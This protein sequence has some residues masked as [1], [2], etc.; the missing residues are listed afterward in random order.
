MDGGFDF[1]GED[2]AV[3]VLIDE[4]DFGLIFVCPII[5][6]DAIRDE[7][8]HDVVLGQRA[9]EGVEAVRRVEEDVRGDAVASAEQSGVSDVDFECVL[10]GVG[11]ERQAALGDAVTDLDEAGGAE[12]CECRGIL[13]GASAGLDGFVLEFS[14]FLRELRGEALPDV[15]DACRFLRRRIFRHV[16]DVGVLKILLLALDKI[17]IVRVTIRLDGLRQA[18]DGEIEMV[19]VEGF[20]VQRAGR[21]IGE[22]GANRGSERI[23]AER[24]EKFFEIERMECHRVDLADGE[25]IRFALQRDAEQAAGRDDVVAGRLL[26]KIFQRRERALARLHFVEDEQRLARQDRCACEGRE[27]G[28]DACGI[29]VARENLRELG[30]T[31]EVEIND[32]LVRRFSKRE[33]GVRLADLARAVQEERTMSFARF[34]CG[35]RL[36]DLS[37][38]DVL[39]FMYHDIH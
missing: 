23:L 16:R 6:R 26:C 36:H 31:F 10:L 39:L 22:R 13:M 34:P 20:L 38:H 7:G 27:R 14:V 11:C 25:R 1:D 28:E 37:F 9:L 4:I 3:F 8:L 5:R 12:P 18:A 33:R 21:A 17:E 29:K 19:E 35:E 30:I 2:A 15:H 24:P 32:V